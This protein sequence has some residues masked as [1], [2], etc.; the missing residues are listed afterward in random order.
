VSNTPLIRTKLQRPPV[1]AVH[2]HR[3]HLF[4]QLNGQSVR[5]LT[6]VS[7]PAGYGKSTLVSSW[8]ESC[9]FPTAWL[10]LDESDNNLHLFLEYFLA[11][12]QSASPLAGQ[13]FQGILRARGLPSLPALAACLINELDKI[14]QTI[15]LV[16][17]DFHVIQN[18]QIHDLLEEV[19][20][21]PLREVRLVLLSRIDPPLSLASLRG[22]GQMN[23]I[24]MRDLRFSQEETSEFLERTLGITIEKRLAA[25]LEEKT[26]GWITGLYLAALSMRHREDLNSV[27]TEL[28]DNNRFVVDYFVAEI[29]QEQQ[30][31]NLEC[32]LKTSILNRF[33]APLCDALCVPDEFSDEHGMDG[34]LFIQH[35]KND[36]LFIVSLD[37]EGLWFRYHHLFQDLLKRRLEK[38]YSAQEIEQFHTEASAWFSEHG[39][40]EEALYHANESGDME[41][42]FSLVTRHRHEIMNS[43]Q[44]HRLEYWLSLLP[45]GKADNTPEIVILRAWICEIW[46]RLDDLRSYL[47]IAEQY[48]E[49]EM[50][51]YS[52]EWNS[53]RAEYLTLRALLYY[54]DGDSDKVI[55]LSREALKD[56]APEAQSSRS[57]AQCMLSFGHQMKGDLNSAH[58]VLYEAI[59]TSLPEQTTYKSRLLLALSMVHWISGDLDGMKLATDRILAFNRDLELPESVGIAHHLQGIYHYL[60]NNLEEAD[61]SLS[62]V[63]QKFYEPNLLNFAHSA[64][65]MALSLEAQGKSDEARDLAEKTIGK[66]LDARSSEYLHLAEAFQA[67]LFLRQGRAAKAKAWAA[68]YDPLPFDPGYRFYV[69]QLT[70]IKVLLAEKSPQSLQQAADLLPDLNAHYAAIHNTR[71]LIDVLALQAL[72]FKALGQE[73]KALE[74]LNEALELAEPAGFIRPFLDLGKPMAELLEKVAAKKPDR[75]YVNQIFAATGT[76]NTRADPP[77]S[78]HQNVAPGVNARQAPPEPLT[79]REIQILKVLSQGLNNQQIADTLFIS[80]E[81][82]KRHLYNIF[83]K[84]DVKNRQQAIARARSLGID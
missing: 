33:C 6:L 2:V 41:L 36:N 3:Q 74:T 65:A 61:S 42:A 62:T 12:V 77:R 17:D 47:Q 64:F 22:H 54:I 19:L 84:F 71:F 7:A 18:R 5:P 55:D 81:T 38:R 21:H 56:L 24:R 25:V 4:D 16:I 51:K 46:M 27:V 69:P 78:G 57:L 60:L 58:R 32:L 28:P 44:W 11:A 10:S 68:D 37:S 63:V 43:E 31:A 67:D 52:A 39:F 76:E 29:L 70:Y 40:V 53:V 45:K 15:V 80:P 34:Q 83:Q 82:V 30:P 49:S 48:F 14:D 26:E 23:E 9:G 8:V 72:L 35:L 66:A 1:P 75:M 20:K 79:N 13:E 59:I 73:S 50:A